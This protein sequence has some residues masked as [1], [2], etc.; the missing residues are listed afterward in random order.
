MAP[1]RR[2]CTLHHLCSRFA[3]ES[4]H[5]VPSGELRAGLGT[6]RRAQS[7]VARLPDR[8]AS[9]LPLSSC[10]FP[11]DWSPWVWE[12]LPGSESM[13][14]APSLSCTHGPSTPTTESYFFTP[15]HPPPA[16]LL[17]DW[18]SPTSPWQ[19]MFRSRSCVLCPVSSSLS[20][21]PGLW[22]NLLGTDF[23]PQ[24][25]SHVRGEV[26]ETR[27]PVPCEGKACVR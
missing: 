19:S 20:Q 17:M 8:Q 1:R 3:F 24:E 16:S 25:T 4:G 6:L 23:R 14:P 5:S 27:P 10:V 13:A 22:G 2:Q 12:G 21:A 7:F 15:P 11:L 18:N 26:Q 9:R